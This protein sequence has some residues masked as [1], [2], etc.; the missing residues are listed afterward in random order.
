MLLGAVVTGMLLQAAQSPAPR[1]QSVAPLSREE[2]SVADS[3]KLVAAS[4]AAIVHFLDEWRNAWLAN[5]MD[6]AKHEDYYFHR[7]PALRRNPENAR[8]DRVVDEDDP[9][10]H[11]NNALSGERLRALHCDFGA[12]A[13]R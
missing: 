13:N 6:F 10:L 3:A 4:R 12:D 11:Y 1:E 8:Q 7:M 9:V 5:E 2:I